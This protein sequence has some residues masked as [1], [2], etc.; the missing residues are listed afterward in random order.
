[1]ARFGADHLL[2]GTDHPFLPERFA[3]PRAVITE[4]IAAGLGVDER[5]L[6][7]NALAFLGLPA[8]E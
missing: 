7:A 4:A 5:A 6:G 3:G 2:Y 1:M 8:G